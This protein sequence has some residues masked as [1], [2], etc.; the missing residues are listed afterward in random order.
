MGDGKM[1]ASDVRDALEQRYERQSQG[2]A[3]EKWILIHEARAGAGFSGN[4]GSADLIAINTW[5]SQGMQIVG[6]EVK[7]SYSD[8]QNELR[9]QDK[10]E[11]FAQFCHRWWV[12][13]PQ[14]LAKRIQHE[15]PETWGLIAVLANGKTREVSPAPRREP[16]PLPPWW[17]VGWMAQLDRMEKRQFTERVNRHIHEQVGRQVEARVKLETRRML[18]PQEVMELDNLRALKARVDEFEREFGIDIH[19]P[20]GTDFHR[21]GTLWKYRLRPNLDVVAR[22]LKEA[23]EML[24]ALTDGDS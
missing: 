10:A 19:R 18:S 17:W 23:G 15:L 9:S 8:W 2:R 5:P 22:Q 3:N 12:A 14:E 6:H 13:A 1:T 20:W 16:K 21:L 24:E 7:V 4:D 11:R